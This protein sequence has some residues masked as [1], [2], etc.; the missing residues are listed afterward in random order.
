MLIEKDAQL[1]DCQQRLLDA[2]RRKVAGGGDSSETNAGADAK[3][4]SYDGA[5]SGAN[6][7]AKVGAPAT[8]D[9][10]LSAVSDQIIER[11]K[12]RGFSREIVTQAVELALDTVFCLLQIVTAI[13]GYLV[14]L[15]LKT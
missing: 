4:G 10:S 11:F 12:R 5:N 6:A 9:V 2:E 3:V 7:G 14:A 13:F 8:A 1:V 15:C